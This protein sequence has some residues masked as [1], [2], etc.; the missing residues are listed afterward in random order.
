MF[1]PYFGFYVY[2]SKIVQEN[3]SKIKICLLVYWSKTSE[4][5]ILKT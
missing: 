1:T 2:L 5:K 3:A 4:I